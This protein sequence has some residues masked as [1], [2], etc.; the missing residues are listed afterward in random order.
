M[1][2]DIVR[3][4]LFLPVGLLLF[5]VREVDHN[6]DGETLLVS[7]FET[8]IEKHGFWTAVVHRSSWAGGMD[9]AG[10]SRFLSLSA[11]VNRRRAGAWG[12]GV[13]RDEKELL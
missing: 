2:T 7:T 1:R 3:I 10:T 5:G 6:R 4:S 9:E 13:G 8:T 12:Q 11:W